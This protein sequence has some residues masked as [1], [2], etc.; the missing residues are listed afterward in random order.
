LANL[1]L[2][3]SSQKGIYILLVTLDISSTS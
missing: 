2:I 3:D 1:Q